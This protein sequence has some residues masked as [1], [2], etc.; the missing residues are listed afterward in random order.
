MKIVFLKFKFFLCNQGQQSSVALKISIPDWT[1]LSQ[2]GPKLLI[3]HY[4][5]TLE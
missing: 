1:D 2:T 4:S 3:L 5:A